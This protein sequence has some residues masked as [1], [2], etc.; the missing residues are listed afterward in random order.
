MLQDRN[1]IQR[2]GSLCL[3]SFK[4]VPSTHLHTR[5]GERLAQRTKLGERLPCRTYLL[6]NIH[7]VSRAGLQIQTARN[8]QV[9]SVVVV[10]PEVLDSFIT[11]AQK[12]LKYSKKR[13]V[14]VV[15][16]LSSKDQT[17]FPNGISY[18]LQYIKLTWFE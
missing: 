17:F 12:H 6:G 16:K 4:A 11:K 3:R 9:L 7:C 5:G 13:D 8:D 18:R 14:A 2:P 1:N 10:Y 15:F